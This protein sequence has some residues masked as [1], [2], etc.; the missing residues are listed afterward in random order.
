MISFGFGTKRSSIATRHFHKTLEQ[1]WRKT[2]G[3]ESYLVDLML[4]VSRREE[5]SSAKYPDSPQ[6]ISR[7]LNQRLEQEIR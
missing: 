2:E 5:Y 1:H 4:L 3:I 6:Q 7:V